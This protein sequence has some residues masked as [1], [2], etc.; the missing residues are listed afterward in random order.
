MAPPAAVQFIL[1]VTFLCV[2]APPIPQSNQ[3]PSHMHENTNI[4]GL[5]G[6]SRSPCWTLYKFLHEEGTLVPG[7]ENSTWTLVSYCRYLYPLQPLDDE[8]QANLTDILSKHRDVG[9][10]VVKSTFFEELEIFSNANNPN[11]TRQIVEN[12]SLLAVSFF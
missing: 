4:F 11:Y 3:R 5:F 7:H 9:E 6:D 2:I 8:S 12:I 10:I 1:S